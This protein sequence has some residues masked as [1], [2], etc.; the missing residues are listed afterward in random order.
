M[1]QNKERKR[2]ASN[3]LAVNSWNI[4]HKDGEKDRSMEFA[5]TLFMIHR[6]WMPVGPITAEHDGGDEC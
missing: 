5:L 4:K 1:K 2:N 6:D 3:W